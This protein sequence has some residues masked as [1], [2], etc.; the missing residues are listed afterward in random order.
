MVLLFRPT[1]SMD[2]AD[3]APFRRSSMQPHYLPGTSSDDS[4][5][6]QQT[7]MAFLAE[8]ERRSGSHRTVEGYARMLWPFLGGFRSPAEVTPAHVLAWAH[9]I[10]LSGREPSSAPVG[11][12][13]A[14]LSSYYR[15]L[16]RMQVTTANPCDALERPKGVQSVARGFGADDVRRLPAVV[17]DTIPGRRDRALLLFFVLTGRRR[18][19]VIGPAVLVPESTRAARPS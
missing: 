17:P 19:E 8:K 1:R 11:A 5:G 14:C 2:V 4:S 6:W 7:V 16:I 18:S 9:G 13:I 3:H 15:F 10:G 12:R